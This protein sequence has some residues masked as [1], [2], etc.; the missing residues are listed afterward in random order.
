MEKDYAQGKAEAEHFESTNGL[1]SQ[2]LDSP[3]DNVEAYKSYHGQGKVKEVRNVRLL[4]LQAVG[5]L[6]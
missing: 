3:N 1:A 2:P 5:L 6:P 4:S